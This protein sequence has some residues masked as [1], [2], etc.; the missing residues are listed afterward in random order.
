MNK[1]FLSILTV[2]CLATLFAVLPKQATAEQYNQN[3]TAI[4]GTGNPNTGWTVSNPFGNIEVALRA[5]GPTGNTSNINGLYIFALGTDAN[6]EFS[7][8]SDTTA[9]NAIKLTT[10][11]WVLS[12]DMDPTAGVSYTIYDPL[13]F[14]NSYGDNST[15][16][17]AGVEDG[18]PG[19]HNIGQNSLPGY[20]AAPAGLYDAQLQVKDSLGNV[21]ASTHIQVQIV[22]EPSTLALGLL[23]LGGLAASWRARRSR[24]A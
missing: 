7:L 18:A 11:T 4:F 6:L 5:K 22:P 23:G 14:D 17:G 3:R 16:N 19:S 9:A 21:L 12:L 2:A 24:K 20:G 1:S 13:T 10:Y 8:N 15:A